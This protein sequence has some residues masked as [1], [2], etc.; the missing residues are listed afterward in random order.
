MTWDSVSSWISYWSVQP[1]FALAGT[2][3]TLLSLVTF[4]LI[5]IVTLLISRTVKRAV[6]R[7]VGARFTKNEGTRAAILRLTHY[8]ILLIGL[9]IALQTVGIN[10]S[11]L[12]A[13][14][15]LFAVAVG[16]AM[17]QVAQN[18][19]SG[20]ILLVERT[21]KPGDILEVEG[22]V[23]R[24]VEMGIRTTVVRT[25]RDEELIMPN[26]ILSQSVV[27]NF[28]MHDE[29][30]R[31]GVTVGVTYG[32][33]MELVRQVLFDTASS[34]SWRLPSPEPRVLLQEFGSSS[35]D[36]GVYVSVSDPWKQRVYMAELREAIWFA[37]KDAGITIAFPQLDVHFDPPVEQSLKRLVGPAAAQ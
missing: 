37:F 32:S 8:L 23:V 1:L 28:T 22:I 14:G 9:S 11:A 27:K 34:M 25:W 33:D 30:Y 26:S 12:F 3:V 2:Q 35:V 20:V 21:I 7:T 29:Q 36:F 24:V 15:A 31:L 19:V 17:Q 6:D 10:M 5:L 13:A 4:V 18:F 16:F